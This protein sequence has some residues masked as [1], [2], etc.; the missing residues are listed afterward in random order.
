MDRWT[1]CIASSAHPLIRSAYLPHSTLLHHYRHRR[2]G[3]TLRRR[4]GGI[5]ARCGCACLGAQCVARLRRRR[6][7]RHRRHDGLLQRQLGGA[8]RITP[9]RTAP[10]SPI[11]SVPV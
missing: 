11:A 2:N 3:A 5:F 9:A 1:G 7:T 10:G 4:C 8:E 6:R